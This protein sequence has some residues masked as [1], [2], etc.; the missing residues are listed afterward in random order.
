MLL[1]LR[2]DRKALA[3]TLFLS[4]LRSLL[5]SFFPSS[6]ASNLSSS[7]ISSSSLRMRWAWDMWSWELSLSSLPTLLCLIELSNWEIFSSTMGSAG[8]CDARARWD[9]GCREWPMLAVC[10]CCWM[11]CCCCFCWAWALAKACCW[12]I[13]GHR[14]P[15][16]LVWVGRTEVGRPLFAGATVLG[17]TKAFDAR[18]G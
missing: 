4:C 17:S 13:P 3:E 14:R 16:L 2:L 10:L 1:P 18:S 11:I 6:L 15:T 7:S 5:L 12:C 8:G 9:E